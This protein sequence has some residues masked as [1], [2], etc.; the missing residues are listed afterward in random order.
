MEKNKHFGN[1][2]GKFWGKWLLKDFEENFDKLMSF[3]QSKTG[4]KRS[5]SSKMI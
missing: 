3:S 4:L 1:R 5:S 2:R